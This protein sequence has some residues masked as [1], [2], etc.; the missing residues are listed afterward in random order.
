V[1]AGTHAYKQSCRAE[2]DAPAFQGQTYDIEQV[3]GIQV[4]GLDGR[5]PLG[6][7][8]TKTMSVSTRNFLDNWQT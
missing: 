1:L 6:Y 8:V 5:L 2:R 3:D 4:E 7:T